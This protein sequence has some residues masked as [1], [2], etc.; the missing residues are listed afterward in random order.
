MKGVPTAPFQ[1]IYRFKHLHTSYQPLVQ[2]IMAGIG[3]AAIAEFHPSLVPKIITWRQD[4]PCCRVTPESEQSMSTNEKFYCF[5]ISV[6]F[7]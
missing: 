4:A 7:Q 2:I 3:M 5:L 1:M 6:H